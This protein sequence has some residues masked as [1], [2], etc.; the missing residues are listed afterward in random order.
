MSVYFKI[1]IIFKFRDELREVCNRTS[2]ECS[3]PDQR[4]G[5]ISMPAAFVH[6]GSSVRVALL[7][8]NLV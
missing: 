5:R 1:L 6:E 7:K 4:A 8:D 3:S 2:L